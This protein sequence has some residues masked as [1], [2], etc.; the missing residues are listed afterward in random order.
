MLLKELVEKKINGKIILDSVVNVC[1]ALNNVYEGLVHLIDL[2]YLIE[3]YK[4]MCII[5]G[6]INNMISLY[7]NYSL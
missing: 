4:D 1:C 2:Y 5:I 7:A 3:L 6:V